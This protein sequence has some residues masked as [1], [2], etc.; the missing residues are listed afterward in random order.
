MKSKQEVIQEAKNWAICIAC[1]WEGYRSECEKDGEYSEWH[2]RSFEYDI[3]PI[4]GGGVELHH[5]N[6]QNK[7]FKP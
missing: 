1:D 7:Q 6:D 4:C 5:I 3:C 2:G